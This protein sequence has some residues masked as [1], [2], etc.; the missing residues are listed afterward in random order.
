MRTILLIV[1][2]LYCI[3][4]NNYNQVAPTTK[5]KKI[6]L[7]LRGVSSSG[8]AVASFCKVSEACIALLPFDRV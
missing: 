3:T 4:C 7:A 8:E 1:Y 2:D 6:L 5:E